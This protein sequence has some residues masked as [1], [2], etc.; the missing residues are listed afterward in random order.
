MPHSKQPRD[1]TTGDCSAVVVVTHLVPA[2]TAEDPCGVVAI[3]WGRRG[4]L[5]RSL[6]LV[7]AHALAQGVARDDVDLKLFANA[8][9]VCFDGLAAQA[10]G[11]AALTQL[12]MSLFVD[13]G[14]E[15]WTIEDFGPRTRDIL[16]NGLTL[17]AANPAD[18]LR[19]PNRVRLP[20]AWTAQDLVQALAQHAATL[21]NAFPEGAPASAR[22]VTVDGNILRDMT[23]PR[24]VHESLIKQ[25]YH[26]AHVAGADSFARACAEL[27]VRAALS[28]PRRPPTLTIDG[29]QREP[30]E[31]LSGV[32]TD[33]LADDALRRTLF[34]ALDRGGPRL[35][36]VASP[37]A[38]RYLGAPTEW[39]RAFRRFQQ[40]DVARVVVIPTWQCEL[41][42]R[43]CTIVKQDGR[44]MSTE[45]LDRA[46]DL[47]FSSDSDHVELHF[48][49]GEPFLNW[50]LMQH[51]LQHGETRAQASGRNIRFLFTTNGVAV[52]PEQLDIIARYNAAMQLSLDG[53]ADVMRRFRRAKDPTV[54]SYV[55]SVANRASWYR[56][57]GIEHSVIQVVHPD[58]VADMAYCFDHIADMGFES[59]QVN[60]AIGVP[61]SEDASTQFANGLAAIGKSLESRWAAGSTVMMVNLL[62]TLRTVRL[63]THP[64]VDFDGTVYGGMGFL[65]LE[66][67]S[68]AFRLGHL[69][70]QTAYHRYLIDGLGEDDYINN[71]YWKGSVESNRTTGAILC[72][73]VR[74]MRNRHPDRLPD[75]AVALGATAQQRA[76]RG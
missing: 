33:R 60:Y 41:R 23:S 59:I 26:L 5:T 2:A 25:G 61:W 72:S 46:L 51:A 54:D 9:S 14:A 67:R 64:T 71:W 19:R 31:Q 10:A 66:K 6:R 13:D 18:A 58:G 3:A 28:T 68:Q 73:F 4:T 27:A 22:E 44:V 39:V 56:D 50:P 30:F 55:H 11:V 53:D 24:R 63:N 74:W 65:A 29:L 45:V 48:F 17:A 70:D 69:D 34:S 37:L 49:G 12:G 42:C 43:Y 40:T 47:L 52:T 62:E 7:D 35:R 57:R 21:A 1:I 15:L 76:D 20:S 36:A 16:A 8:S 32:A 75:Q 38:E